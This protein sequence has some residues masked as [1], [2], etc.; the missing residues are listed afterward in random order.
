MK[1]LENPCASLGILEHPCAS[2][3]ILEN[4]CASLG[5]LELDEYHCLV[6][7]NQFTVTKHVHSNKQKRPA[8]YLFSEDLQHPAEIEPKFHSKPSTASKDFWTAN[9]PNPAGN[10]HTTHL[11]DPAKTPCATSSK[12]GVVPGKALH[13]RTD[14]S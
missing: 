12:S 4:P 3:G 13:S 9:L 7:L 14:R 10:A 1:I 8:T 2:L 5:I 6:K 11:E